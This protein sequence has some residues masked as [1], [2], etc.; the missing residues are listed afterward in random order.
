VAPWDE[1][2]EI[3]KVDSW[4]ASTGF[5]LEYA[6]VRVLETAGFEV[7]AGRFY[8]PAG[9][10]PA[11]E[12]DIVG[13]TRGSY[14]RPPIT[15]R[16]VA[17]C[18]YATSPWV[19][20]TRQRTV[21]VQDILSW[22]IST[23]AARDT[24]MERS[25]RASRGVPTWLADTPDPHGSSI[26]A[27]PRSG[28][29]AGQENQAPHDAIAQV[30]D[31]ARGIAREAGLW[32]GAEEAQFAVARAMANAP[33]AAPRHVVVWPL[34][35]VRGN[36]YQARLTGAGELRTQPVEWQRVIWGG[37]S[38]KPVVV[39]VVRERYLEAYARQARTGLEAMES[40]LDAGPS[41]SV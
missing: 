3:A 16:L 25:Q 29:R 35:I 9:D 5:P 34:L 13:R 28:Q 31:A 37:I 21:T 30:V 15:V 8:R 10:G 23:T 33:L 38:G 39:D 2:E 40:A 17:E 32:S 7:D 27:M 4:L 24:L 19:V 20:L 12:V 36:L 41:D 11:R 18:K 14:D 22:T 6:S 1:G 26:A